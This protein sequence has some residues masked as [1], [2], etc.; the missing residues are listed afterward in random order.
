VRD[1]EHSADARTPVEGLLG[2]DVD[3]EAGQGRAFSDRVRQHQRTV[4]DYLRG[5][6]IPRWMERS[7]DI[8]AGIT[9][10]RRDL[11]RARR[12]LL[13]AFGDDPE[14]FAAHWTRLAERRRFDELN[15]L[16]DQHNEWYPV[17][18]QLPLNPR[19]GEYVLV[20]GRSYRRRRLDA[21]WILEEFPPHP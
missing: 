20:G 6:G 10:A 2:R 16:I 17:E 13:A 7:A 14:A 11:E 3:P 9:R 5:G 4:E 18:R 21:A 19:T 1:R 12:A 15:E 8:D